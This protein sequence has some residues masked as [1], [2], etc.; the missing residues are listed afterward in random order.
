MKKL[1]ILMAVMA[2][3][4]GCDE[5]KGDTP[6][7]NGVAASIEKSSQPE[8]AGRFRVKRHMDVPRTFQK[9]TVYEAWKA[10]KCADQMM[11][12]SSSGGFDGAEYD[13]TQCPD[14][15]V[16]PEGTHFSLETVTERKELP[17]Q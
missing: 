16:F 1:I 3:L 8:F 5:R 15:I 4:A 17:P 2:C 14:G 6:T 12:W 9:A 11:G 7:R 13:V 10:P